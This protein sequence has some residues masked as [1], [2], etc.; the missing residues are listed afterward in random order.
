MQIN[1]DEVSILRIALLDKI[2]VINKQI[3]L[4][5]RCNSEASELFWKDLLINHKALFEKLKYNMR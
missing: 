1:N 2:E 3:E 5:Q 4:S